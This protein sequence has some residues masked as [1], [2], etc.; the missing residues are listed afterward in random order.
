MNATLQ[1]YVTQ[2]KVIGKLK[3]CFP[4]ITFKQIAE[5][6]SIAISTAHSM[7]KKYEKDKNLS[8]NREI[9][10]ENP[11]IRRSAA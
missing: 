4:K 1:I 5:I 10:M 6:F 8:E 9:L 3:E 7:Y 11:I 2:V